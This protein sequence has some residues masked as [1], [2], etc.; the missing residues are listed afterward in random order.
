MR[1]L[2]TAVPQNSTRLICWKI[3][4]GAE[5]R[6]SGFTVASLD[7]IPGYSNPSMLSPWMLQRWDGIS[8]AE[9]MHQEEFCGCR[10][11]WRGSHFPSKLR[12]VKECAQGH[13]AQSQYQAPFEEPQNPRERWNTAHPVLESFRC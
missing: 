13:T 2:P 12:A 9:G 6:V 7:T 8:A 11:H 5:V 1:K 3:A 10:A 4:V